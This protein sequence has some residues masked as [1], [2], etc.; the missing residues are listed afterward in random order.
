MT[1]IVNIPVLLV[2]FQT[3]FQVLMV[4]NILNID[5]IMTQSK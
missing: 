4:M 3:I 5:G 1:D 2:T